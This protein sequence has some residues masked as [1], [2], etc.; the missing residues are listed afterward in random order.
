MKKRIASL[1]CAIA[2]MFVF[3]VQPAVAQEPVATTGITVTLRVE[4]YG[5]TE[6][7][8]VKVTLPATYQSFSDY[9]LNISQDPGYDTPLHVLAQY[10]KDEYGADKDAMSALIDVTAGG[11]LNDFCNDK[12]NWPTDVYWM[13]AVNQDACPSDSKGIGYTAASCPI[14]DGDT[15]VFYASWYSSFEPSNYAYFNETEAAATIDQPLTFTLLGKGNMS[16]QSTAAAIDGASLLLYDQNGQ[17]L[18]SSDYTLSSAKTGADGKDSITF[19]KAGTYFVSAERQSTLWY[20]SKGNYAYNISNPSCK[21]TVTQSQPESSS[22]S[23]SSQSSSEESSQSSSLSSSSQSS[24]EELSQISSSSVSSNSSSSSGETPVVLSSQWPQ[25]LGNAQNNA[26]TLASTPVDG[27]LLWKSQCKNPNSWGG[28]AGSPLLINGQIYVARDDEVQILNASTGAIEKSQSLASSLGY[29]SY[30]TY[31][32]GKLFVPLGNGQI[33][34]LNASTLEPLFITELMTDGSGNPKYQ[35]LSPVYYDEADD[36]FYVGLTDASS[37]GTF[38]AYSAEDTDSTKGTETIS[39]KWTYGT[40]SYYGAGAVKIED[41]I[42]FCGD[43]GVL[44]SADAKTG[45]DQSTCQLGKVRTSLVSAQGFLWAATDDGV[46]YKITPGKNLQISDSVS[47]PASAKTSPI[48][49][50]GKVFVAGGTYGQAGYLK[51][52]DVDDLSETASQTLEDGACYGMLVAPDAISNEMCVYLT[53]NNNPGALYLARL[54]GNSFTFSTL[55]QPADS[56]QNYCMSIVAADNN[57]TLYY[58]NDSGVLF[59]ITK[60]GNPQPP[61]PESSSS[62]ASSTPTPN[63]TSSEP[64]GESSSQGSENGNQDVSSDQNGSETETTSSEE[65]TEETP[66]GAIWQALNGQSG[67]NDDENN[68]TDS[69]AQKVREAGQNGQTL[70]S[71]AK[72]DGELS[73]QTFSELKKYPNLRLSVDAG[74]YAISF[75]GQDVLDPTKGLRLGI[76]VLSDEETKAKLPDNMGNHLIIRFAD[77]GKLPAKTTVVYR[78]PE[79]MQNE[80]T[81]YVYRLTDGKDPQFLQQAVVDNKCVMFTTEYGGEYLF[82]TAKLGTA[83]T[84]LKAGNGSNQLS[85]GTGNSAT[86]QIPVWAYVTFAVG[87]LAIVGIVIYLVHWKNRK[88]E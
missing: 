38:A 32:N 49:V 20:D 43:D 35:G 50:G 46:L 86:F 53:Q 44:V 1:F 55:Y 60:N 85:Q 72:K 66:L 34:V 19:H 39:P 88:E 54:N 37:S 59:A 78:L 41:R 6:V 76:T 24:S 67:E 68:L 27:K 3:V 70:L 77:S 79:S 30:P 51:V 84:D 73:S 56:Q 25:H 61:A 82:T 21:V 75:L 13:Y 8:P 64:N 42:Y 57:G 52:F 48:V 28:Y 7:Q 4:G 47:L 69:I 83:A 11:F 16:A 9:G 29:Y 36:M 22:L 74:N 62:S 58:G 26:T 71:I 81:I 31:G 18:S 40:G 12:D 10:C 15:V 45:S 17:T 80:T 14:K 65:T 33:E 2:F 63:S 5:N 87:I 23:S